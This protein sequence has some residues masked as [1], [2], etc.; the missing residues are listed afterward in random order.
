MWSI[1]GAARWVPP[2]GILRLPSELP[3]T[4]YSLDRQCQ[5]MF[6]EE[7]VH[8]PNTSDSD[9]CS[10]LWCR[11]E[12]KPHCTTRNGSLHWADGTTCATNMSCLH[13]ACMAA[14]EVMQPKVSPSFSQKRGEKKIYIWSS[15]IAF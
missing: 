2:E 5:Q 11:E 14:H 6:G 15:G 4:T 1:T 7:F 3:G 9:V 8:C 10:Q 12:G 13:G